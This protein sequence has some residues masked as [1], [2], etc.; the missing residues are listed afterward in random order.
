[1]P[2]KRKS[3]SHNVNIAGHERL[4]GKLWFLGLEVFWLKNFVQPTIFSRLC[5]WL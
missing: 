5:S 3:Y 2:I 4:G 1:M